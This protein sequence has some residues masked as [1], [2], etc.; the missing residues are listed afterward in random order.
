MNKNS[1]RSERDKQSV[2]TPSV[3]ARMTNKTSQR[4]K[5][6]QQQEIEEQRKETKETQGNSTGIIEKLIRR[7]RNQVKEDK[8]R[9]QAG[10][11]R[12]KPCT[13]K[14][15]YQA[16]NKATSRELKVRDVGRKSIYPKVQRQGRGI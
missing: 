16:T 7:S 15:N 13:M 11:D 5:T 12:A 8:T 2:P 6:T 4:T 9:G 3:K 10:Q 14:Q 1:E